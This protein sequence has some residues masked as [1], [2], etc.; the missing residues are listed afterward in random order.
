MI[1]TNKTYRKEFSDLLERHGLSNDFIEYFHK[2]GKSGY[3]YEEY[4]MA[5]EPKGWI[6]C[7]FHF[8]NTRSGVI[9]WMAIDHAWK[10]IVQ[11]ILTR[12]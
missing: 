5:I 3:D 2:Y 12:T 11:N 10:R 1:A 4:F 6:E 8:Q 9:Y 7:A